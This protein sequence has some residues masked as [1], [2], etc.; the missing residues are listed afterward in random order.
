MEKNSDISDLSLIVLPTTWDNYTKDTNFLAVPDANPVFDSKWYS[1]EFRP[2]ASHQLHK[3]VD[4]PLVFAGSCSNMPKM[5]GD[6]VVTI[7]IPYT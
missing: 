5:M 7:T 4:T 6:I 2:R 3:Y 1:E